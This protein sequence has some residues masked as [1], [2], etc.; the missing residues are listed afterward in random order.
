MATGLGAEVLEYAGQFQY[1]KVTIIT[2][3]GAKFPIESGNIISLHLYE[4]I[5]RPFLTGNILFH[6]SGSISTIGP[7]IGQEYLELRL[8]TPALP[9][10]KDTYID[11]SKHRLHIYA[12]NKLNVGTGSET[13][14][15]K[16]ISGEWIKNMR[17]QISQALEGSCSQ[18]VNAMLDK[19]ECQ[20]DRFIE[21][22]SDFKKIV[23]PNINPYA[24][25]E[26]MKRQ[27][28]TAKN[29]APNYLFWE[30]IKGVHFRSLDSIFSQPKK[31]T[32]GTSHPS[33]STFKGMLN[34]LRDLSVIETC[35]MR[36]N[37]QL[38][39]TYE[40]MFGSKLLVHDIT[41]KSYSTHFYN[42]FKEEA[43]FIH[44]SDGQPVY[45]ETP[46][47]EEGFTLADF[48]GKVF[49]TSDNTLPFG[50]RKGRDSQHTT[51]NGTSVFEPYAPEKWI[52]RRQSQMS[53]FNSGGVTMTI[54]VPGQTIVSCGDK[55][56]IEI[57]HQ[58]DLKTD[59]FPQLDKHWSGEFMV[60]LIHHTF[61]TADMKH[62]MDIELYKDSIEESL[63]SNA[64]AFEPKA[65]SQGLTYDE[66]Y[67]AGKDD[68]Y[69]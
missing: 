59:V 39:N 24:V 23:A 60:K 2:S 58:A 41:T 6:N 32:Y 29:N 68:F 34:I 19:V 13:V 28:R 31:W 40:G 12:M 33:G 3:S 43:G 69:L 47:N 26:I 66:F 36:M 9:N 54:A 50:L 52:Q 4:D 42:Y 11:Y 8:K 64:N 48:Q 30:S 27:A 67:D 10:Q 45:S 25:I 35:T 38:A 14:R 1:D 15:I 37:D 46:V 7:I 22:S 55:L 20:K 53:M 5:G 62:K 18:I 63:D 44:M 61:T 57:P 65:D 51:I 49:L 21:D 16:F 17:V 56:D